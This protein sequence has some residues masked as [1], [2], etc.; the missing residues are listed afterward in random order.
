MRLN[1]YLARAG[2]GSRRACEELIL[3]G[4]VTINGHRLRELSTRVDSADNVLVH[5]KPVKLPLPIVAILHK[6]PGYVC[7]AA[8]ATSDHTIYELLPSGWPRV[9]YVG[10]LD[11]DSEGLLVVTN[12]GNLAQRLTHPSTKI[13]KTYVVTLDR[14]FDFA[15]APKMRKGFIIDEGFARMDEIFRLGPRTLKV[16]LTQGLKRQI[17]EMF[18]QCGFE[19]RRLVRVQIGGLQIAGLAS[20][21]H[22]VLTQDEI[23]RYFS[24]QPQPKPKPKPKP[25]F[26]PKP[27][28]DTAGKPAFKPAVK[29]GFKPAYKPASKFSGKP[30]F[31]LKSRPGA[32]PRP[33][34]PAG[35]KGAL[36]G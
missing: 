8:E 32:A 36:R 35:K 1:Q 31:R 19:V 24:A 12:D 10:R 3:E 6:P 2:F 11:K 29:A 14:E 33:R 28:T 23:K 17:R 34:R 4:A 18:Y 7:T 9:V 13:P 25:P 22:R 20:G 30:P 16:V 27:V 26:K 5:G 15:L 21:A